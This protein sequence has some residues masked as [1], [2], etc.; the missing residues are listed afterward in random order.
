MDTK[1]CSKCKRELP[2]TTEFY[3][4]DKIGKFGLR[5][6]CKECSSISNRSKGSSDAKKKW[7]GLNRE[8]IKEWSKQY[9][10][11]NRERYREQEKKYSSSDLA[12][13]R[14]IRSH[15]YRV[16]NLLENQVR[17][18]MDSQKGC[19]EICE[20]SLI[21]PDSDK[22]YSV[23]HNHMTGEVRG[24]LCNSC[25]TAIGHFK[26]NKKNLANAIKYLEKHNG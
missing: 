16:Y 25:N 22:N 24:L 23:D 3:H 11:E 17:E 18:L 2:A 14:R 6:W 21:S 12:K 9:Y 19:C 20:E 15:Y 5:S 13:F 26:E 10:L 4:R 8:R 1:I 7:R